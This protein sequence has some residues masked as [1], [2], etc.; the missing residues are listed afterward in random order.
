MPCATHA[1]A[2]AD[3]GQRVAL[4]E[5]SVSAMERTME[6]VSTKL[7]LILAQITRV[8]ILE[9]KHSTQQADVNR[10]HAKID[11]LAKEV[12]GLAKETRAFISYSQGRDKVLWALGAVVLGLFIKALF[13][14]SSHGMTP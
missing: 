7:D 3:Q 12:E 8:A 9:E 5:K 4:T 11:A 14:A 10:A 13:F 1:K 2:I 6:A